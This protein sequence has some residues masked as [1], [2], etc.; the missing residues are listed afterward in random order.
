LTEPS[1]EEVKPRTRAPWRGRV[2]VV[3]FIA[4][5]IASVVGVSLFRYNARARF[6]AMV[7]IG[8]AE[9]IRAFTGLLRMNGLRS[10]AKRYAYVPPYTERSRP[11]GATFVRSRDEEGEPLYALR[12]LDMDASPEELAAELRGI[13]LVFSGNGRIH[14]T[15]ENVGLLAAPPTRSASSGA[16]EPAADASVEETPAVLLWGHD[17]TRHWLYQAL[18]ERETLL[19]ATG[20]LRLAT[21]AG[22][23]RLSGEGVTPDADAPAYLRW[24]PDGNC[25]A[26][27]GQLADAGWQLDA[28][29][30]PRLCA[31]P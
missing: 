16:E 31:E 28:E 4:V 29:R 8:E 20:T 19:V 22:V 3:S 9:R 15:V 14:Y 12:G 6:G 2:V 27:T 13:V 1:G 25:V 24:M 21:A 18:L 23:V 10:L 7:E 5:A 30:S 11:G 17:G 26:V